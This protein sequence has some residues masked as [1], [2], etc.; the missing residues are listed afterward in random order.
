MPFPIG[1]AEFS[2]IDFTH[3][4]A[5][6][7]VHP[8]EAT[9]TLVVRQ[10]LTTPIQHRLRRL[11]LTM[12]NGQRFQFFAHFCMGHANAGDIQYRRMLNQYLLGLCWLNIDPTRHYHVTETVRDEHIARF[13]HVSNFTQ[14]KHPWSNMRCR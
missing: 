3:R 14:G 5:T 6:Q 4:V 2:L 11:R 8:L 7:I 13:I 10:A 9:W 1:R 12:R